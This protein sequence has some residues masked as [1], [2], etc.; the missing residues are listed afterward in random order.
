MGR[1]EELEEKKRRNG[2]LDTLEQ[3]QLEKLQY[4]EKKGFQDPKV[5]DVYN[6]KTPMVRKPEDLPESSPEVQQAIQQ[7]KETIT[8]YDNFADYSANQAEDPEMRKRNMIKKA[9]LKRLMENKK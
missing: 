8:P 2:R 5:T 1:L 3:L 6:D 9:A 4:L 7:A